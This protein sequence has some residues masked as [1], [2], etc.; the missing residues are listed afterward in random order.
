MNKLHLSTTDFNC[1]NRV[2]KEFLKS[3]EKSIYD[4]SYYVELQDKIENHILFG[5]R[6][7]QKLIEIKESE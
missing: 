1:I 4:F 3:K 2:L 7:L 6:K 5:K